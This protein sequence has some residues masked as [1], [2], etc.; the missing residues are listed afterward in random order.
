MSD[1]PLLDHEMV[2]LQLLARAPH[3]VG[4]V[5]DMGKMA[6]ALTF[7]DLERRGLV[8]KCTVGEDPLWA[9]SP[10]GEAVLR[11]WNDR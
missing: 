10:A 7:V 1:A 11:R 4:T 9:L 3:R 6:A 8:Q 2:A 5:D